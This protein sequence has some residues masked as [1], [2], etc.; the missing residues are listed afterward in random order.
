ASEQGASGEQ[1]RAREQRAGE[2]GQAGPEPTTGQRQPAKSPTGR[3]IG[4]SQQSGNSESRPQ[5]DAGQQDAQSRRGG[6]RSGQPGAS[7]SRG[8]G[9]EDPTSLGGGRP[10]GGRAERAVAPIS[11]NDY[12]DW[13][14]R[15]RDVEEMVDD[16]DLRAEA[17][18]I[19]DR[20]RGIRG[21]VKRH[22]APPNWD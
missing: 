17:A 4:T 10:F 5:S 15:L 14:D 22:S 6:D 1:G 7:A 20:A 21:E 18:R 9:V 3:Q 11:G 2:Q 12:L 13:S 8:G 19:R 16:P